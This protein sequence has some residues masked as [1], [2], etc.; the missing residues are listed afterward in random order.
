MSLVELFLHLLKKFWWLAIILL[1]Y[2]CSAIGAMYVRPPLK[3]E[4]IKIAH[5]AV[6]W[7]HQSD[8]QG[9]GGMKP[10]SEV[11]ILLL[12]DHIIFKDINADLI[13]WEGKH[14]KDFIDRGFWVHTQYGRY[15][16]E[17][18]P[19]KPHSIRMYGY[20]LTRRIF[21]TSVRYEIREIDLSKEQQH[22]K[23]KWR[24]VRMVTFFKSKRNFDRWV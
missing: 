9:G 22:I 21:N 11:D 23:F 24:N 13:V 14:S 10:L 8:A 19:D 6:D 16:I 18:I 20:K 15:N 12:S 7:W 3:K 2:G 1:P 17:V 4:A 5:A